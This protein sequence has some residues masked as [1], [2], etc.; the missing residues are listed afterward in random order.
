MYE[1]PFDVLSNICAQDILECRGISPPDSLRRRLIELSI[2]CKK[3]YRACHSSIFAFQILSISPDLDI[4]YLLCPGI[5]NS[6]PL[7][8]EQVVESFCLNTKRQILHNGCEHPKL[9][10]WLVKD[11]NLNLGEWLDVKP[12]TFDDSPHYYISWAANDGNFE[13]FKLLYEYCKDCEYFPEMLKN[14]LEWVSDS[15][16][17][18]FILEQDDCP[19]E[20]KGMFKAHHKC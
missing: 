17:Q 9:M 2:V 11:P 20:L 14:S 4:F 19:V 15:E 6:I 10:Q 3:W 1:L 8:C 12:P 7:F 16:I 13:S 5:L 18:K